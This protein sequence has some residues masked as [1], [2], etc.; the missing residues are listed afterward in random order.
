MSQNPS[1]KESNVIQ[2][3]VVMGD[4]HQHITVNTDEKTT[5]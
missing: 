3:S 2:D 5:M 1:K 4:V